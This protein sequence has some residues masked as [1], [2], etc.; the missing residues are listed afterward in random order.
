M[1]I[2]RIKSEADYIT[3]IKKIESLWGAEPDTARDDNLDILITLVDAYESEHHPIDPPDP[4]DAI[5]FRMEQYGIARK[6]LEPYIGS[7]GRVSEVLNRKREL[8]IKMIRELH[9]NL[10]I[11]LESLVMKP[12]NTASDAGVRAKARR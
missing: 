8:S 5:K 6:D 4:I 12:R 3:A 2:K 7:R 11:P 1:H 10:R 9:E